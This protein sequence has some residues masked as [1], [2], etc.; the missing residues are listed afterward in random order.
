MC[1]EKLYCTSIHMYVYIHT[2]TKFIVYIHALNT[3]INYVYTYTHTCICTQSIYTHILKHAHT[4]VTFF[5]NLERKPR[6]S[7]MYS[8][9][10]WLT[11]PQHNTFL[12]NRNQGKQ[13]KRYTM[14]PHRRARGQP[15]QSPD[16]DELA[17]KVHLWGSSPLRLSL[18]RF[19][20]ADHCP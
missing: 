11:H 17:M 18:K 5:S 4:P 10:H 8:K 15:R 7:C 16:K 2:H 6:A 20:S 12:Y 19:S 1:I 3:H 9:Y 13:R 14:E